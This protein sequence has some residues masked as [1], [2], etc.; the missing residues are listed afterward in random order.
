MKF[1]TIAT[2]E[3]LIELC[4]RLTGGVR[5][6]EDFWLGNKFKCCCFCLVNCKLGVENTEDSTESN[7]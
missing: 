2:T 6:I 1:L 7:E 5:E 3:A 4:E